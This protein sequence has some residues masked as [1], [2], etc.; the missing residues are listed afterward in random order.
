[1]GVQRNGTAQ[2]PFAM[3]T[4]FAVMAD[5][6]LLV[7]AVARRVV[8]LMSAERQS[9]EP[10]PYIGV[11]EAARYLAC[12]RQRIYDLKSQGRLRCIKDGGRLTRR[13]WIDDYLE[14]EN[15]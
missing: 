13:S 6:D 11:E 1:L 2:Q 5:S 3:G 8:E 15:A 9:N 14:Q 4:A 10:E 12:D 7:E